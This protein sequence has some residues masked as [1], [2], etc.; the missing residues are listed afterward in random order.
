MLVDDSLIA[1]FYVDANSAGESGQ[2]GTTLDAAVEGY[3]TT[4][5]GVGQYVWAVDADNNAC[6]ALVT[7][8]NGQWLELHMD[9]STWT[10]LLAVERPPGNDERVSLAPLDPAEA[11]RALLRSPRQSH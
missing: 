4:T 3:A 11:L 6:V 9:E 8:V 1:A 7:E 10:P 5:V 2:V